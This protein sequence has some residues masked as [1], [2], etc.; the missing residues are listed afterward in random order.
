MGWPA[1]GKGS[2]DDLALKVGCCSENRKFRSADAKD[3][4]APEMAGLAESMGV[5]SL[6]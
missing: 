1:S 3:E 6:R 5:G 2:R 4:L